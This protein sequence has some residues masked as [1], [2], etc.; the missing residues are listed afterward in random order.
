[1]D[2]FF[3]GFHQ[4]FIFKKIFPICNFPLAMAGMHAFIARLQ[5][6]QGPGHV[7]VE[8]IDGV[9]QAKASRV[10]KQSSK[11]FSQLATYALDCGVAIDIFAAGMAAVNSPMLSKVATHSGGVLILHQS[12]L[13]PP[14]PSNLNPY[15]STPNPNNLAPFIA[16]PRME[17]Q[18]GFRQIPSG[19]RSVAAHSERILNLHQSEFH[20]TPS[21]LP[22]SCPA[23]QSRSPHL[24]RPLQFGG[25]LTRRPPYN[26]PPSL[27]RRP[28]PAFRFVKKP[29][30]LI[31]PLLSLPPLRVQRSLRKWRIIIPCMS[32]SKP[33]FFSNCVD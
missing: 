26:A 9:D 21:P 24:L 16:L 13:S 22:A 14:P 20:P 6:M 29:V 27:V 10:S 25:V 23:A 1:L 18:N 11:F 15:L 8:A 17:R 19:Q 30:N 7:L 33:C 31:M 12:E 5:N 28:L 4:P 32:P 2:L 3:S